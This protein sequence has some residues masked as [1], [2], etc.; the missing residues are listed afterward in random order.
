[1]AA[2]DLNKP[3]TGRSDGKR[4]NRAV[5]LAPVVLAAAG[6]VALAAVVWIA[7][8]DDPTGGQ[9]VA[10]AQIH[11]PFP[12]GNDAPQQV[13]AIGR[14]AVPRSDGDA[15]PALARPPKAV[16]A[17]A[18]PLDSLVESS[19]YGP[20]PRIA[21]DGLRPLDAYARPARAGAA[22][23]VPRAVIIVGGMG[24]SQTATQR[25]IE[26]LPEDV[27]LAFAPYG[28]SLQRWSAKARTEGHEILMQLPLE[29][30]GYPQSDP[31]PR[32]LLASADPQEND[33]HLQWL[34]SR[35]TSYTGV[36]NYMGARF[37]SEETALGPLLA[38][39]AARGL[40]FVDDGS[41]PRSKASAVGEAIG[42]PVLAT[43]LVIDERRS[44]VEIDKALTRLEEMARSRGLAVG[45]A[46]SFG[47]TVEA[48]ADWIPQAEG[49][50]LVIVPASAALGR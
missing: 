46:S 27:T 23:G 17:S 14:S 10:V 38:D 30:F 20:V 18:A 47:T 43:D 44:R 31:G 12:A 40:I 22:D 28:A 48:L 41:S 6:A 29:P 24:I 2:D 9:P 3:L 4:R 19:A 35:I 34:L 45:V 39:L 50:G 37:T 49:R 32:T 7:V 25:A 26:A 21:P 1:M 42:A 13:G 5:H 36:M 15:A 11:D 33:D 16:R 8:I